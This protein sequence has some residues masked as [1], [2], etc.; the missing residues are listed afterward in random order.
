MRN[1]PLESLA[2][3]DM[4]AGSTVTGQRPQTT[5]PSQSLYL[6]NSTYVIRM[7]EFA[8][9]ALLTERPKS[10]PAR[11]KLAYERIFNRSPTDDETRAAL[12]F[13][14]TKPTPQAGWSAL[15]QSLWASHEFLARS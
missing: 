3:F 11:V 4:T 9:Q 7:A 13:V 10:E 6:L 15:C 8:A 14:N 1:A 12:A 2:L 5:V